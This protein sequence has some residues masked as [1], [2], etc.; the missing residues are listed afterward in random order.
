MKKYFAEFLATFCLIFIGIGVVA[1][2]PPEIYHGGIGPLGIAL[3]W[4]IT[5]SAMIYTFGKI[6]GAHMNPAV[7]ITFWMVKLFETKHVLP[8]IISQ[9]LGALSACICLRYL[10]PLPH[11]LGITRPAIE[12]TNA[13]L[14]EIGLSF[15]LMLVILFTSQG[16][17][18]TGILSGLAVGGIILAEILFGGALTGASMNPARSLAPAMVTMYFKHI[19]IY[20]TAPFLGMFLAGIIWML[21]KEK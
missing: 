6:S 8:Y 15:I 17:K 10:F 4:G 11:S 16:S 14:I 20:L 12:P 2:E 13:F 5:V 1:A 3:V 7:T 9:L 19:W 21:M 18:E